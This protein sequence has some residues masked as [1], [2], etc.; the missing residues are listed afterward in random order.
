MS[1][2]ES[3]GQTNRLP[4]V[5]SMEGPRRSRRMRSRPPRAGSP[6][7]GRRL[8]K[9]VGDCDAGD[10]QRRERSRSLAEPAEKLSDVSAGDA[11]SLRANRWAWGLCWLMFAST[12]LNYMDRQTISLVKEHMSVAFAI[13]ADVDFGWVLAAFS[14]TYALFQVPAGF[15]VDRWDLR[16]SYAAAVAWWSLAAMATAVVPSLGML[17]VCRALLGVGESFNWPC[18]LR[19]TG[20]V[21]PPSDR[22]LG[23]GIFNSGAAVGAVVTPIVVTTLTHLW[24][25]RTAFLL[26]GSLGFVWVAA[27]LTLVQGPERLL[28]ARESA[29]AADRVSNRGSER[30]TVVNRPRSRLALCY[31]YR[32]ASHCRRSGGDSR[33]C[34]SASRWRFSDHWPSPA[35]TPK[36]L[37]RGMGRQPG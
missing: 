34:G 13:T 4:Q 28:L 27:W 11:L 18:A 2:S 16:W 12:V 14:M 29:H 8:P 36:R 21:L 24:G 15:L 6:S 7:T 23:N 26:I 32:R 1:V 22:S 17:I 3:P 37:R 10:A 20:R 19:V 25:W 35:V 31:Y 9:H 30:P 5:A 33:S